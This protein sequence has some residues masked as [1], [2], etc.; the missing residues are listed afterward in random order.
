M[1]QRGKSD[2]AEPRCAECGQPLASWMQSHTV[3]DCE[4]WKAMKPSERE[5]VEH[6]VRASP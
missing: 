4:R 5:E 1:S 2:S 6:I 3:E